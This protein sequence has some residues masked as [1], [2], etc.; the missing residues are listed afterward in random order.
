MLASRQLGGRGQRLTRGQVAH[1]LGL[2][3]TQTPVASWSETRQRRAE[4]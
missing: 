4:K 3:P 1:T 2:I